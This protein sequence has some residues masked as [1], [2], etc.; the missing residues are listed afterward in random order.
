MSYRNGTLYNVKIKQKMKK[1]AKET[2]FNG[3]RY[4][5]KEKV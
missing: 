5:K 2:I 4:F 3:K 1:Y